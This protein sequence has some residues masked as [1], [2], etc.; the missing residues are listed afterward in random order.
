[1]VIPTN[2]ETSSVREEIGEGDGA[3]RSWEPGP[4][5]QRL[6][7]PE[8][9]GGGGEQCVTEGPVLPTLSLSL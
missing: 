5:S 6:Q 3:A 7:G 1:M 8:G 2:V 9:V 4:M